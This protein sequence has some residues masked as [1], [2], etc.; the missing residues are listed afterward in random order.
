[1]AVR[2]EAV[3]LT[4][5]LRQKDFVGEARAL[6]LFCR[7]RI[8]YV[9]DIRSVETLHTADTLL[10]IRCGDCDDKSILLAA[11]LESIGHQARFVAVAQI[12]GQFCHVWTQVWLNGSWVDLETTEPLEFGQRIP[13]AGIAQTIYQ[14][15]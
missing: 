12:P 4:R 15:V 10:K 1:M 5:Q 3:N 2:N 6:F 11:L 8:R 7:D 9:R 14:E 13:N